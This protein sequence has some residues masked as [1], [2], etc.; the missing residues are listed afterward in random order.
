[1]GYTRKKRGGAGR[2]LFGAAKRLEQLEAATQYYD[3]KKKQIDKCIK[4]INDG[5][6]ILEIE[7]KL[8]S[9]SLTK[10]DINDI[11]EKEMGIFNKAIQKIEFE[12]LVKFKQ[13]V[14]DK[15]SS[16]SKST[17]MS[18]YEQAKKDKQ[19]G[20]K[21]LLKAQNNSFNTSPNILSIETG[22]LSLKYHACV[23]ELEKRLSHV[24]SKLFRN[25]HDIALN[26]KWESLNKK[27]NNSLDVLNKRD[28]VFELFTTLNVMMK[29]ASWNMRDVKPTL[30]FVLK[31]KCD[32]YASE[33]KANAH[34]LSRQEKID[35]VEAL[36]IEV[37]KINEK[38]NETK[39]SQIHDV[40]LIKSDIVSRY[41]L[42]LES[43]NSYDLL[44]KYLDELVLRDIE[45]L[46]SI[47]SNTI[48]IIQEKDNGLSAL[49]GN[50]GNPNNTGSL[51]I[52]SQNGN[53]SS[54]GKHVNIIEPPVNIGLPDILSQKGNTSSQ[55]KHVN[56]IEPPFNILLQKRNVPPVNNDNHGTKKSKR[57]RRPWEI[58]NYYA[59][60]SQKMIK[61]YPPKPGI[62]NPWNTYKKYLNNNPDRLV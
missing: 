23:A 26:A 17:G 54:Q 59:E 55:G 22:E 19:N 62:P 58:W 8:K 31:D 33:L 49:S 10:D 21:A 40:E 56:I 43:L 42:M 12:K 61:K 46:A 38:W 44:N 47:A 11:I 7:S 4:N 39:R 18:N 35:Y 57:W 53:T 50:Y 60:Q 20:Y 45:L 29:S 25:I 15:I 51:H 14:D 27:V 16:S 41:G 28:N 5:Q 30:L 36:K 2:P 24:C 52:L 48:K 13:L 3:N 34:I 1:M 37:D 6:I 32:M 9:S